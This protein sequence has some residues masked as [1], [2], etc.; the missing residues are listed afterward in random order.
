MYLANK[1]YL[2]IKCEAYITLVEIIQGTFMTYNI[3]VKLFC[4]TFHRMLPETVFFFVL[5]KT[6]DVSTPDPYN[7]SR[8]TW[9]LLIVEVSV[10]TINDTPNHYM[11]H[12]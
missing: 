10:V 1:S 7:V 9:N 4:R 2:Y 5:H 8:L 11:D 6:A 12:Y 3:L